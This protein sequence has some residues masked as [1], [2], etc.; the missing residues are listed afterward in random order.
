ML[1]LQPQI[2]L[3]S[4]PWARVGTKYPLPLCPDRFAFRKHEVLASTGLS[5]SLV[6]L[7]I[8]RGAREISWVASVQSDG[9]KRQ[10]QMKSQGEVDE[11]SVARREEKASLRKRIKGVLR[12]MSDQVVVSSSEALAQRVVDTPQFQ[13]SKIVSIYL[14]MPKE[15]QTRDILRELFRRGKKVY[16]PK[17]PP[18]SG[19]MKITGPESWEMRMFPLESEEE[20]SSFPLTKWNI[21]EPPVDLVM[22]REDGVEVGDI[23]LVI[24]PGCGF[25]ERCNRLG[26]GKGYYDCFFERVG[27]ANA[28]KGRPPPFMMGVCLEEQVVENI[29]STASDVPLD[30]VVTPT[31]SFPRQDG[32]GLG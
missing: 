23:D 13:D 32:L 22:S 11:A 17:L 16:I 3:R 29:P 7:P 19:H 14:S 28:A 1:L 12:A 18:L 6:F 26:H 5:H 27:R 30:M 10:I 9:A 21:P 2:Y 25:D 8:F 20:V 4:V 31:R 24:T 15:V